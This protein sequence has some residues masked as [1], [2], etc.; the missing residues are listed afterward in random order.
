MGVADWRDVAS[1]RDSER[2]NPAVDRDLLPALPGR[3]EPGVDN[4]A[5]LPE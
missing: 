2:G 1:G 3:A 4:Q 5:P